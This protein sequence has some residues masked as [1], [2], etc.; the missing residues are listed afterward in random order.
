MFQ[1]EVAVD[2]YEICHGTNEH[3]IVGT[4]APVHFAQGG[5]YLRMVYANP[6]GHGTH[7]MGPLAWAGR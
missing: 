1:S 7:C 4:V 2:T 3:G 6:V 5:P